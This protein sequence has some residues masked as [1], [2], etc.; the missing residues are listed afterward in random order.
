MLVDDDSGR[1]RQVFQEA[2]Q[3]FVADPLVSALRLRLKA[4]SSHPARRNASVMNFVQMSRSFS[5]FL[6]T[7][8]TYCAAERRAVPSRYFPLFTG[9]VM[10]TCSRMIVPATVLSKTSRM[11][12]M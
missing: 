9:T 3:L 12:A 10:P 2:L 6:S 8:R 5:D 7:T 11:V 1:V 4:I